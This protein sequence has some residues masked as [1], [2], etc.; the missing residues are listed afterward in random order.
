MVRQIYNLLSDSSESLL[1]NIAGSTS[2]PL[3]ASFS[4]NTHFIEVHAHFEYTIATLCTNQHLAIYLRATHPW[5]GNVGDFHK[6]FTP[7]A[8]K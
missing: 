4:I 1:K 5:S 2:A 3:L 7:R 8:H 6:S